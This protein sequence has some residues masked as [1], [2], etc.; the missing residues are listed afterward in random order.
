[1]RDNIYMFITGKHLELSIYATHTEVVSRE[2]L[3][4]IKPNS[5]N[6]KWIQLAT[7]KLV[8]SK[9]IVNI[10]MP[11][12]VPTSTLLALNGTKMV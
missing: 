10:R 2:S 4:T 5:L 9:L 11:Y 3:L 6:M 12:P 1:M 7:D 8:Q